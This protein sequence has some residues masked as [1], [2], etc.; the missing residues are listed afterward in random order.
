MT[1]SGHD[2]CL[3]KF[4]G[5]GIDQCPRDRLRGVFDWNSSFDSLLIFTHN[6][7]HNKVEQGATPDILL[8]TTN[9][10]RFHQASLFSSVT[11]CLVDLPTYNMA[12]RSSKKGTPSTTKSTSTVK[13][14]LKRWM[15]WGSKKAHPPKPA[16]AAPS[17]DEAL[18]LS[19]CTDE[20]IYDDASSSCPL[21]PKPHGGC[22]RASAFTMLSE[23]MSTGSCASLSSR[24]MESD[25]NADSDMTDG[26]PSNDM[27]TPLPPPSLSLD[28]SPTLKEHTVAQAV[29]DAPS[30]RSSFSTPVLDTNQEVDMKSDVA[31]H[32]DS[33]YLV[34]EWPSDD[35][36][37][38]CGGATSWTN[39]PTTLYTTTTADQP[40]TPTRPPSLVSMNKSTSCYFD[41]CFSSL[42]IPTDLGSNTS[43]F[44]TNSSLSTITGDDDDD[45]ILDRD[46]LLLVTYGVDFLKQRE[47]TNWEEDLPSSP[48]ASS[49]LTLVPL[50]SGNVT[51]LVPE[52][53]TTTSAQDDEVELHRLVSTHILF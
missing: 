17:F 8:F 49:G 6:N 25:I 43:F 32:Q 46:A 15:G 7:P 37:N 51:S 10:R 3:N 42:H 36:D 1:H 22:Q 48:S 20:A 40:D 5:D 30:D 41:C 9:S 13:Q 28:E 39:Q 53:T 2:R 14:Y 18:P 26:S 35:D 24:I 12:F 34:Y 33:K 44:T 23:S 16:P 31:E 52:K 29:C 47:N 11:V 19:S 27:T 21:I 38:E 50:E 45:T 4:G